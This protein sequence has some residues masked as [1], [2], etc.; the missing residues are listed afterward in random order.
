MRFEYNFAMI[1]YEKIK[2]Y[3]EENGCRCELTGSMR[4]KKSDVGDIDIVLGKVGLENRENLEVVERI[5]LELVSKYTEIEN[6]INRY[7]FMLKN[8]ISIHVI[9]EII[10]HFNYT[11]WHSTG[12]KLHVKLIKNRY[13]EKG[14]EIDMLNTIEKEIYT[15]IGL[16]YLKPEARYKDDKKTE[17]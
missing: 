9:P 5:I 13:E 11:L 12:P 4:R 6:K 15:D 7:E 17:N 8:G 16:K 2:K 10:E 3:L 14:L 1:E